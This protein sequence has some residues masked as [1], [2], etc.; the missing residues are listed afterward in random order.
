MP[1]VK[2]LVYLRLLLF[3]SEGDLLTWLTV[4]SFQRVAR[5][6]CFTFSQAFLGVCDVN[7]E[8]VVILYHLHFYQSCP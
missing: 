2:L 4:L 7:E 8:T 5:S 3:S 6:L 1:C